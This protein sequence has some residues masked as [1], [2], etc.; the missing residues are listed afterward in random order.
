M[1]WGYVTFFSLS[2]LLYHIYLTI[3]FLVARRSSLTNF[4]LNCIQQAC[5]FIDRTFHSLVMLCS[6][7]TWGLGPEPT[8]EALA[9]ELTTRRSKLYIYLFIIIFY[10]SQTLMI[11]CLFLVGMATM[12]ENKGKGLL[13]V[14]R[15][16]KGGRG[17]GGGR[18]PYS[19]LSTCSILIEAHP[20]GLVGKE[21][22][23]V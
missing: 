14:I 19:E 2:Y 17:G 10:S 1:S 22:D 16:S 21:E 18:G 7:A 4:Y 6:L 9:H 11:L 13:L 3:F 15:P 23:C 8:E 12:K 5:S 20:F